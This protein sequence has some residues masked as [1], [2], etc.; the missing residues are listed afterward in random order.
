MT[1]AT[2]EYTQGDT[3]PVGVQIGL[4]L[5]GATSVLLHVH[6][7]TTRAHLATTPITVTVTDP[8]GGA[9]TFVPPG[10]LGAGYYTA[11]VRVTNPAGT[12]VTQACPLIVRQHSDS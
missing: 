9:G 7:D 4:D 3:A 6:T 10:G 12:R 2:I 8:T 1:A 5:T 11:D